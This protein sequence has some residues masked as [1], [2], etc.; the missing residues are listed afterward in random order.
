MNATIYRYKVIGANWGKD[1]MT[2]DL[3]S[4][5]S[6]FLMDQPFYGDELESQYGFTQCGYKDGKVYGLFIQKYPTTL[7]DY[8]AITKEEIKNPT[9][10]CGEY[11]FVL[12]L[13]EY[14]LFLQ[15][16]KISDLPSK[17]EINKRFVGMLTLVLNKANYGFKEIEVTEDIVDRERIVEIFYKEADRV[18]EMA[19]DEFDLEIIKEQK[20][21]R[22]GKRQTYFNPIEAYQE[23]ME[24]G[25]IRLS[26]HAETA[27]IKAKQGES[28]KK[29]PI[30]RAMLEASKKPTKIVYTVENELYT[31]FGVT[32]SKETISIDSESF[33]LNE[34]I[35]N[36]LTILLGKKRKKNDNQKNGNPDQT[37]L[38]Q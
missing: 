11:L 38:F 1:V 9:I 32:K 35:E 19:F 17:E 6:S 22:N 21:K 20:Q 8:D 24:E 10:D 5:I 18:I 29:D 2:S 12:N 28:L 7:I 33:N 37:D 14:E 26:Q 36:I 34:Q 4:Q 31:E 3:L 25:A 23:A 13:N 30:T 16:K 15:A 27:H